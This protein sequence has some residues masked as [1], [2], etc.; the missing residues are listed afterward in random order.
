ML[1]CV[2]YTDEHGKTRYLALTDLHLF[3]RIVKS[4]TENNLEITDFKAVDFNL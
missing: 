2:E 1:Y 4:I 3:S